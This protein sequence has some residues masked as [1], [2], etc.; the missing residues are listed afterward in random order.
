MPFCSGSHHNLKSLACNLKLVIHLILA[1]CQHPFIIGAM[2]RSPPSQ[3]K[4][5]FALFAREILGNLDECFDVDR[6]GLNYGFRLAF[7]VG[8]DRVVIDLWQCHSSE[9][10][11]GER[12]C[13][14]AFTACDDKIS[15][16]ICIL[17]IVAEVKCIWQV[18]RCGGI[19]NAKTLPKKGN[20]RMHS[21]LLSVP[22][23]KLNKRKDPAIGTLAKSTE[24][25]YGSFPIVEPT[26]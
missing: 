10:E 18:S 8:D 1:A 2:R 20:R 17:L 3:C 11:F 7:P 4:I 14:R 9:L 12:R 13:S 23:V 25:A 22:Y 24:Y 19:E 21:P 15:T 6:L 26:K 16:G 5:A